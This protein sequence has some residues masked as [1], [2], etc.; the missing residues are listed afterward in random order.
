LLSSGEKAAPGQML[1][2]C[3]QS[4]EENSFH[5]L[6][7]RL[8]EQNQNSLT[9]QRI[10]LDICPDYW[11]VLKR[12][13]KMPKYLATKLLLIL[14]KFSSLTLGKSHWCLDFLRYLSS[15]TKVQILLTFYF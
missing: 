12:L 4:E 3:L 11:Q 13:S 6:P 5:G 14:M 8:P 7:L 15:C 10:A 9:A 2:Q 1:L